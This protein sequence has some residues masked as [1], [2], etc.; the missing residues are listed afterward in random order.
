MSMMSG[1]HC[2]TSTRASAYSAVW[3]EYVQRHGE[4]PTTESR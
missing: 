1:V 4:S 3:L 2:H